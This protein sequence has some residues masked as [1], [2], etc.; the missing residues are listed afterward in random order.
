MENFFFTKNINILDPLSCIIY[1]AIL[2][3]KE[4][5]T[6]LS[7]KNSKIELQKPIITQGIT[8]WY[9][10][11]IRNDISELC[12]PIEKAI[13]WYNELSNITKIFSYS[14]IGLENLISCYEIQDKNSTIIHSL[15]HYKTLITKSIDKN[16]NILEESRTL[17]K[18]NDTLEKFQIFKNIWNE[19]DI[20]CIIILLDNVKQC[21]DSKEDFNYY[22]NAIEEILKGKNYK[23]DKLIENIINL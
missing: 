6:K 16:V 18:E 10:C 17:K 13:E 5:G 11:D 21:S 7:I 3:F 2:G 8:R 23:K 20:E 9:N 19:K 22:L 12:N 1:L 4:K 15:L 14:I